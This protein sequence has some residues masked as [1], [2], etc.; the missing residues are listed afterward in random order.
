[1]S[2]ELVLPD[3]GPVPNKQPPPR[4]MEDFR[5]PLKDRDGF[6]WVQEMYARH[7]APAK[8]AASA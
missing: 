8:T 4:G 7:R 5:A 6:R 3:G 2:P 1:M